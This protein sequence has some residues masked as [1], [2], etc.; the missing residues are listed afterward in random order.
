MIVPHAT[1]LRFGHIQYFL[2]HSIHTSAG[3]KEHT[4]A[5]VNWLKPHPDEM[6]FG[7]TSFVLC[8][9]HEGLN[10]YSYIPVQRIAS[11]CCF[12]NM[13]IELSAGNEDVTVVIPI[14]LLNF[15]YKLFSKK[16]HFCQFNIGRLSM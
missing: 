15:H 7:S 14:F 13:N 5:A 1:M 3:Q 6:Y 16:I 12:G 11:R 10:K 2:K 4:L 9:D 8:R